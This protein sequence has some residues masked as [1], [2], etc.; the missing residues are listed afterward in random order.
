MPCVLCSRPSFSPPQQQAEEAE[1]YTCP[2][3]AATDQGAGASSMSWA[4]EASRGR[5]GRSTEEGEGFFAEG[6]HTRGGRGLRIPSRST[7]TGGGRQPPNLPRPRAQA[8]QA[9][10]PAP[11]KQTICRRDGAGASRAMAE[12]TSSAETGPFSRAPAKASKKAS[13]RYAS[14]P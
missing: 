9:R 11:R 13:R 12:T 10:K 1:E 5:G 4:A 6:A 8:Q 2:L 7:Q 14:D 3:C